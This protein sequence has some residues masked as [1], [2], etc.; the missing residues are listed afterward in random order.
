MTMKPERYQQVK[1]VFQSALECE[2]DRLAAFL[3]EACAGDPSLRAEVEA[4]LA[5]DARE[6]HIIESPLAAGALSTR[7]SEEKPMVGARIGPH[8]IL[9]EIGQGGIGTVYLAERADQAFHKR[10]AIKLLKRGMDSDSVRR[11][12]EKERQILAN[13]DHTNIAKLL[14]GGTAE[15]GRPYFVMDYIEGLPIDLYCD[16][17]HLPT[18]E[19]LEL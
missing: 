18:I 7:D 15:D 12:F 13:L 8:Q 6:G 4:L 17:H 9:H 11:R 10:V 3:A 5:Y 14:D 16:T 2:P 19:R 1:Q